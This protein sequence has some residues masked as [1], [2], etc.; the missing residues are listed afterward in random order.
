MY[1]LKVLVGLTLRFE[2]N[3]ATWFPPPPSILNELESKN[4]L[5]SQFFGSDFRLLHQSM[6]SLKCL[7]CL[8]GP[9]GS[10]GHLVGNP[11]NLTFPQAAMSAGE[12]LLWLCF[13][14][15]SPYASS[16]VG[17]RVDEPA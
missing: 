17:E 1:S 9:C 6:L 7:A 15:A 13:S 5:G 11:D 8:K 16:C 4:A 3:I 12:V 10:F 14:G 2:R